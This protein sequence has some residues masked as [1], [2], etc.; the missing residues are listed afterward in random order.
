[1]E[2]FSED[3]LDTIEDILDFYDNDED[4]VLIQFPITISFP[5]YTTISVNDFDT[6]EDLVD[7]C[8]EDGFDEDI[9]CID[10]MYPIQFSQ[11]NTVLQQASVI[12]INNDDD[13]EDI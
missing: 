1:M 3:D 4:T 9:E 11:Y 7:E 2:V 6:L 8:I 12:D 5:D 13:A 10:I